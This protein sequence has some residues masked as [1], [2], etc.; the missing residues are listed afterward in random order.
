M[1]TDLKQ[2]QEFI[3]T[4]INAIAAILNVGIT[5]VDKDLVRI[6][7]TKPYSAYLGHKI[8][9]AA[10]YQSIIQ[11]GKP[12][13]IKN[14]QN[15]P[16]CRSCS[17]RDECR[18]LADIA[19][20][21]FL[22]GEVSGIISI[23]AFTEQ[24]K[25]NLLNNNHKFE[26]FLHYMSMLIESKLNTVEHSQE[27][28]SQLD[29]VI[30]QGRRELHKT[31][32]IGNNEKIK[33]ILSLML[34]IKNSDS[35][36]LLTGES[37]TGKEVLAR[38]I[39]DLSSRGH[40]LM[41][42]VNCGAIPENLVESELFGYDGGAFT[43]AKKEG[44][45]GKFEL[46]NNSTLFLDEIGEMPLS[47]QTTL[48]RVLQEGEVQRIGGKK[49]LP[50]DVR[51][52]CATNQ[53]L[54][55]LVAEQKF[56]MDLYYRINVI[57]VEIPPLR[58][59][60]DDIPLFI[61]KF[62]QLYNKQLKKNVKFTDAHVQRALIRYPWPGNVRELKNII[63]YLVNIK[64]SGHIT[65]SDLPE[66]LLQ[67]T[68]SKRARHHQQ[69]LKSLLAEYEKTILADMLTGAGNVADKRGVART[70]GISLATLY[71]KMVEYDL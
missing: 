29:E 54:R 38:M 58:Q 10:F 37:G 41:I 3:Q 14:P 33:D 2:I 13:L 39:H 36:I 62:S 11:T 49:A 43:G 50:V 64:E 4:L 67:P 15:A 52:I 32:F 9:H 70:L 19:Y 25:K 48:L 28:D 44:R 42:P 30:S 22:G 66:H 60:P 7:A 71:R 35:T 23:I 26:D 46:A 5:V 63:E 51:I 55:Q 56:R 20:P 31:G 34:R 24:E 45:P 69:P 12:G 57:P 65:L 18:E 16:L 6:C 40:K 68:L 27:L 1:T 21:I 8:T 61:N 59:R 47:A 53:N 17:Y